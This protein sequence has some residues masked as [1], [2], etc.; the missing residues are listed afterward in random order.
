VLQEAIL[1]ALMGFVPGL[2]LSLGA[3][4]LILIATN[5]AI[6]MVMRP[7][8]VVLVLGL[9]ILTCVLSGVLSLRKIL[10]ADPASVL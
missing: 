3:Y 9:V 5:E 1:L 6:P 8:R 10:L 2:I 4:Q 7:D